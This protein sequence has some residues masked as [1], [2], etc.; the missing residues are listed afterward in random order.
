MGKRSTFAGYLRQR[1]GTN[2]S[3]SGF[4]GPSPATFKAFVAVTVDPTAAVAGTGKVLPAGSIPLGVTTLGG[5]TGGV[6]PTIDVQLAGGTAAGLA[7]ELPADT[8]AAAEVQTGADLGVALTADTEIEA[9]VGASAATGG[10]TTFLVSYIVAD[11]G[12]IQD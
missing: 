3:T 2:A 7:N 12:S 10:I 1:A 4:G 9:G 11:S 8:A 5:A 6:S